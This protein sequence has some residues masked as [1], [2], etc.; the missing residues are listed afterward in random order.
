MSVTIK[1]AINLIISQKLNLNTQIVPIEN[2]L[3]RVSAQRIEAKI[4]LPTFDNSAMDGYALFSESGEFKEG[5]SFEVVGKILAGEDKDISL[6][7][8]EAVRIM[9]GAKVPKEAQTVIPQENVEVIGNK[10]KLLK[11]IKIDSNIRRRGEDIDE[12]EI[13]IERGEEI[14]GA[15]IALFA[16]Q[17]ITHIEVF[18]KPRVA[19]LVSGSELKLHFEEL[20]ESQIYNSNTYYLISRAKELGCEVV[21]VGKSADDLDSI[22]NLIKHSLKFDLIITSGGVSVGEADYTKRAFNELGFESLFSKVK[23][24]PGKPTTFGKIGDTLVLNLPGNPLAAALNFEIFGR[25]LIH[26]LRGLEKI[27]LSFIKIPISKDFKKKKGSDAVIPGNLEEDSFTPLSKFGPGMVNV[28]N[29]CNGFVVLSS[30]LSELKE[31]DFVK[32]IPIDWTLRSEKF[33]DF[34]TS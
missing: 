24:R 15:H 29:R 2:A 32:F 10:I 17:G 7:G 25:I 28:L 31:G 6:K 26:M 4:A 16:S 18:S 19:V 11:D 8:F 1:E 3:G 13:V 22:K 20:K 9:T 5:Y 34:I 21:F 33:V 27:H 12:G 30:E 14:K 23:I